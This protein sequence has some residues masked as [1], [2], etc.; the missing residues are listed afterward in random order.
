METGDIL[1]N[2]L[3][4]TVQIGL[5]IGLA[6]IAKKIGLP[7]RWIPILDLV[8]GLIS[9]IFVFGLAQGYG[10]L[11]GVLMGLVMGLSACGLFSG[12][13]NVLDLD[14]DTDDINGDTEE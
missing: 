7:H 6:E 11:Y 14:Y 4:P 12:V 13:K 2:I 9:G 5:I 3:S 10:I 1:V 8:L